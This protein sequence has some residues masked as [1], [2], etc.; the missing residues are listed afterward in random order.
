[1]LGLVHVGLRTYRLAGHHAV[2]AQNHQH[3]P[4]RYPDTKAAVDLCKCLRDQAGQDVEPMRQEIFELEQRRLR[5]RI[6]LQ[7]RRIT[8]AAGFVHRPARLLD[9]FHETNRI[10]RMELKPTDPSPESFTSSQD[11]ER[12]T[13]AGTSNPLHR[14]STEPPTAPG[15]WRKISSGATA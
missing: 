5:R 6:C 3:P 15:D 4:F 14:W 8:V 13:L 2:L 11:E 7:R 12:Q 9:R 10:G 1:D